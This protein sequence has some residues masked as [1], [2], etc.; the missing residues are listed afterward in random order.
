MV[1]YVL[2]AVSGGPTFR[3]FSKIDHF[4]LSSRGRKRE[5]W[6]KIR[7]LALILS[8]FKNQVLGVTQVLWKT[9]IS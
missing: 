3:I 9:A 8:K 7:L 2:L 4:D 1:K 6:V 5:K